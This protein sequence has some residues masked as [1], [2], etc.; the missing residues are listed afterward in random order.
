MGRILWVMSRCSG[1]AVCILQMSE[2]VISIAIYLGLE[3]W[4]GIYNIPVKKPLSNQFFSH[5]LQLDEFYK[6]QN[7]L[8]R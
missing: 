3:T 8:S 5:Q 4:V 2:Q 6:L 7:L 1:V